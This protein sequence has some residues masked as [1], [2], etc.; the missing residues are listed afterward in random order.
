MLMQ[1]VALSLVPKQ[2]PDFPTA[3]HAL[4]RPRPPHHTLV[5]VLP[6]R[7]LLDSCPAH[8]AGDQSDQPRALPHRV[9]ERHSRPHPTHL[10]VVDVGVERLRRELPA[11][12]GAEAE[13]GGVG[14]ALGRNNAVPVVVLGHAASTEHVAL[15]G[16]DED[17]FCGCV[18]NSFEL[19]ISM[20]SQPVG[21]GCR[22]D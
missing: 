12:R 1:R 8:R 7:L 21:L 16:E 2:G 6:T 14:V 5:Q 15:A 20:A 22:K 18:F 19:G 13:N 3:R 10:L 11:E 9:G 4:P 17:V